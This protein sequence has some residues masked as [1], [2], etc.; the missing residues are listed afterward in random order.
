MALLQRRG[1]ESAEGSQSVGE[2]L[3]ML[4]FLSTSRGPETV[5]ASEAT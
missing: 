5:E 2:K 3:I 4:G 1:A